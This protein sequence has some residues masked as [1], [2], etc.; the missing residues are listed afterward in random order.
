MTLWPSFI[1]TVNFTWESSFK[2]KKETY[3]HLA[4]IYASQVM[5]TAGCILPLWYCRNRKPATHRWLSAVCTDHLL[6]LT[7]HELPQGITQGLPLYWWFCPSVIQPTFTECLAYLTLFKKLFTVNQTELSFSWTL[8]F[9]SFSGGGWK[10]SQTFKNYTSVLAY[11]LT[12]ITKVIRKWLKQD[13]SL[14]S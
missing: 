2:L 9:S 3:N 12:S 6:I 1:T 13:K 11:S 4:S 5:G 8:H 7:S 14:F 10:G